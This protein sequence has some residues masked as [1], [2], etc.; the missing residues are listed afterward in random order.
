V[1]QCGVTLAPLR[2][3]RALVNVLSGQASNT[4]M[5]DEFFAGY[6]ASRPVFEAL[7]GAIEDLS[8]RI[9]WFSPIR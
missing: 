5:L 1:G 9:P 3:H 4:M 7:R 6:E 2:F 8:E